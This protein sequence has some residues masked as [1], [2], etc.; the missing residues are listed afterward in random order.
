MFM[1]NIPGLEDT[2]IKMSACL[3]L[4]YKF[5]AIQTKIPVDIFVELDELRLILMWKN[6][7]KI[8]LKQ[9]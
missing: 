6:K 1:G 7:K 8:E 4:I 9:L 2:V 3:N 5:K